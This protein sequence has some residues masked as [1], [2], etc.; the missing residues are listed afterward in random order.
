MVVLNALLDHEELGFVA[1]EQ[2][3][4]EAVSRADDTDE[5]LRHRGDHLAYAP[6]R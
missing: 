2:A 5:A 3:F 4:E 6:L 1:S